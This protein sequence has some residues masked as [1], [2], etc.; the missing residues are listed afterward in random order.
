MNNAEIDKKQLTAFRKIYF[1]NRKKI[2]HC[3]KIQCP[4]Q[5]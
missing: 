2:G 5:N 4:V 1:L 3:N